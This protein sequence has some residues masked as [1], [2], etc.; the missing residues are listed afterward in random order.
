MGKEKVSKR[1]G[2]GEK[3]LGREKGGK[4]NLKVEKGGND[5]GGERGKSS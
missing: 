3:I 2:K 4:E 5:L 1:V